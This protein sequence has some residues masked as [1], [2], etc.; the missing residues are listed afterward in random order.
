MTRP[1]PEDARPARATA[2]RP[3]IHRRI[4]R[5]GSGLLAGGLIAVTLAACGSSTSDAPNAGATTAPAAEAVRGGTLKAALTGQPDTLD[6]AK[7]G[8]YVASQIYSNVFSKLVDL[9]EKEEIYGVLATK[10]TQTDPKTWVFE[11]R[12]DVKFHNGDPFTAEDVKFTFERILDKKTASTYAAQ[13]QAIDEIEVTGEH[14]VT[15]RLKNSFGPFLNNL[16]TDGYIVNRKVIDDKDAA[17][18]PIGTGPFEFVEWVQG[19]HATLKR[20]ES[21]FDPKLPLLDEIDFRFAAVNQGR[22]DGLRSGELDWVDGV[23]L[24]L[25]PTLKTA[26]DLTSVLNAGGWPDYIAFNVTKA[27]FNDKALRQAVALAVDKAAFRDVAYN[28]TGEIG[29][30]EMS[31]ESK[32]FDGNEPF[33]KP[34]LEAAKA[35]LAESKYPDG[36]KVEFIAPAEYPELVK[37]GEVLRDQLK[38]LGIDVKI[39]QQEIGIWF[40]NFGTG[41]FQALPA[42]QEKILDPDNFFSLILKTGGS[43]N[44]TGYSNKQADTLIEEAAAETDDAKRKPLYSE[45]RKVIFDDVPVLFN[46][47][48]TRNYVMT[49]NVVPGPVNPTLGMR[50]DL[51]GKVDPAK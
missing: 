47:Y 40:N 2:P 45:L 46:H 19:D 38:P 23:P 29:A 13:Y 25:V 4:A 32:W 7:S 30:Q 31:R 9:N 41:N 35:K 22:I 33:T 1:T 10:W 50:L 21:Y 36:L 12:D 5:L 44:Y 43:F 20:N 17:R 14:E 8:L 39:T 42:Y 49:K 34:D 28:G 15:F 24:Q 6:P 11:L 16:A 51:T 18:K 27:P 48:E 26:T 37:T 3:R